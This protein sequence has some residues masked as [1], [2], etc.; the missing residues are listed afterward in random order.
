VRKDTS[1]GPN[2]RWI[3]VAAKEAETVL[4]LYPKKAMPNFEELKPSLVFECKNI[5]ETYETMKK[6][7]V[8]LEGEPVAMGF[9][10]FAT[11]FDESGNRL[12]LR[13]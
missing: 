7:G 5:E 9:G 4:V 6:N 3:E 12:G 8:E 2:M 1:M 13:E 11:F 10:K